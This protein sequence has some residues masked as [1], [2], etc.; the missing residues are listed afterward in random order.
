MNEFRRKAKIIKWFINTKWSNINS[1]KK[2]W[3][4]L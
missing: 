4:N 1:F 3:W 2:S